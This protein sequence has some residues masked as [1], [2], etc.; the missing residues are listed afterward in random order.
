LTFIVFDFGGGTLDI[1]V[2]TSSKGILTVKATAGDMRLG[3]INIDNLLTVYFAN[4]FNDEGNEFNLENQGPDDKKRLTKLRRFSRRVKESLCN[5]MNNVPDG[6]VQVSDTLE[7]F[8][9]GKNMKIKIDSV[10]FEEIIEPLCERAIDMVAL[11][12]KKAN[13]N[14]DKV[15]KCVLT[16][17]SSRILTFKKRLIEFFD[18]DIIS[19]LISPETA[20]AVGAAIKG[21]MLEEN[22]VIGNVREI[23]EVI[24]FPLGI[25]AFRP[26]AERNEF[27]SE[28][29]PANSI[30]PIS[31]TSN[32]TTSE[33][34]QTAI[35]IRIFEN[36]LLDDQIHSAHLLG[37]FVLDGL[38]PKPKGT[39]AIKVTFTINSNQILE[40]TATGDGQIASIKI[41]EYARV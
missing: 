26:G 1:S 32:Y 2:L 18:K 39:V 23:R 21:A 10:D 8:Y 41:T 11:A 9:K 16:G 38:P 7:S 30:Y 29:I 17:G 28:I 19:D 24:P 13:I 31:K 3:G 4:Q 35:N 6:V 40:V 34:N 15:N 25:A 14:K 36:K 20:I 27:F 33:D 37:K 12:L 5:K 22:S